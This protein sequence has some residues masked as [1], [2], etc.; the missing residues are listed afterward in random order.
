MGPVNL[1]APLR[2]AQDHRKA[3]ELVMVCT[4]NQTQP[5]A[6]GVH[7]ALALREY[8]ETQALPQARL[9]EFHEFILLELFYDKQRPYPKVLFS[10]SNTSR[11]QELQVP[12]YI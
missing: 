2:W 10:T 1:S 11:V 7:P 6:A 4:D 9:H 12:S 8:R 5:S 3:Y